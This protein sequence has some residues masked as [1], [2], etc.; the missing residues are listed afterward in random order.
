MRATEYEPGPWRTDPGIR[1]PDARL[2]GSCNCNGVQFD[3]LPPSDKERYAGILCA[4]TSCRTT[5]GFEITAWTS[6]PMSQVQ[7]PNAQ[8][9]DLPAG[10]LKQYASSPG[11]AR[12]FCGRCGATVFCSKDNQSWID[13]AAGLLRAE[14]GARAE[15]WLEWQAKVDFS[16][17][18]TD[19]ELIKRLGDGLRRWTSEKNSG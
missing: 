3:I 10:T 17:E 4:C 18:A 9:L 12:H 8:P 2:H 19:Q 11:V 15:R 13:I 16:E 6:V 14:E 1:P 5:T 7:S